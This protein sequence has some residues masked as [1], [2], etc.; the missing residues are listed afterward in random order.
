MGRTIFAKGIFTCA[1]M[2][3]KDLMILRRIFIMKLAKILS[4]AAAVSAAAVMACS[5]SA[6]LA[7]PEGAASNRSAA[8]S[9]WMIK[10]YCPSENIDLGLDITNIGKV[11]FTISAAEPEWFE[12]NTGGGVVM[13]CGPTSV[14]P[15]DHNWV[16]SNWWGVED[17]DKDI[18]TVNAEE[19]IQSV[20]VGDYTYQIIANV[21][22]SNCIYGEIL[23][24][25]DG[26]AQIALQEWGSDMS[27]IAVDS[28]ELFDKSGNSM[29]KFDDKGNLVDAAADTTPADT[30]PAD[31][32]A[33]ADTA[34]TP[35]ADKGS[36]DTGVEGIAAVAGLAA[37][38]A[39]AV[40]LTR[41]RK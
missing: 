23:D 21:D 24:S 14:T 25:A 22:D 38:A 16:S 36:P 31:T 29:A 18:H 41:K 3:S 6:E 28:L 17:E 19:A 1:N 11:V 10:L 37:V 2:R 9:M 27:V 8:A 12:G 4:A 20:K 35:A 5:A 15:A 32:T 40:V 30:T 33:P 26:Y 39:G 7:I 34:T 13:S